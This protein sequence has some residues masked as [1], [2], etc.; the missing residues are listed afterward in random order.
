MFTG[1]VEESATV[2]ALKP[3]AAAE[4]GARLDVRTTLDVADT[5]RGDSIAV[6]GCCLT[7]VELS[8][9][10]DGHGHV[11]AFD[12]GPETLQVTTLGAL[13]AGKKVHLERALRI[14]DRLGGHIVAGHVDAVGIVATAERR[15]DALIVRFN[16]PPSVT[17]YCVAKGSICVD[18]VSL[19]LNAVDDAGFDVG[20]IPH[21]L[22]VTHFGWLQP[23]DRVNLEADMLGKYVEKLLAGR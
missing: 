6:D 18:G 20:L 9:A 7:V 5:K 16:A 21:T 14:G 8:P 17:R 19:T 2:L 3:S 23:G 10:P 11:V 13:A 1:I 12:L 22:E 4:A 15:G